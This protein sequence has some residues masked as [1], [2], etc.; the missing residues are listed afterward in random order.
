MQ[1]AL[2]DTPD[3]GN[4][5]GNL[6]SSRPDPTLQFFLLFSSIFEKRNDTQETRAH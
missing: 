2:P 5:A 4:L 6:S 1:A 3:A